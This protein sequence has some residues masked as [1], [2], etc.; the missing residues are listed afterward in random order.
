MVDEEYVKSIFS[1]LESHLG[2]DRIYLV[3]GS[4]RDLLLKRDFND[5]DFATTLTSNQIN[6]SSLG[7][8]FKL[9]F[10]FKKFGI[11]NFN[12]EGNHITLAT[13]RKEGKYTDSRHPSYI[14]FITSKEVD[15]CRRDFTVN[16]IYLDSNLVAYDPQGGLADLEDKVIR[17]IG[18]IPTRMNE[19]PLRMIRALRFSLELGF[20]LEEK[21][22]EYIFA[23]LSLLGLLNPSKIEEEIKKTDKEKQHELINLIN[24]K[25]NFR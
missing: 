13:M 11:V 10:S 14:E 22:K 17:M 23:H 5:F 1:L 21:L 7:T 16:S 3:G 18:D 25:I 9:D 20:T 19:D 15:S 4:S 2:K 12:Y 24:G 6:E 8:L